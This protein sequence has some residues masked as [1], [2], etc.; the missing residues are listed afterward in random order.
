MGISSAL[1]IGRSAPT[2]AVHSCPAWRVCAGRDHWHARSS[3]DR[4]LDPR[5]S[6]HTATI[7]AGRHRRQRRSSW[8]NSWR[9]AETHHRLTAQSVPDPHRPT[10]ARVCGASSHGCPWH[11]RAVRRQRP[12]REQSCGGRPARGA[13]GHRYHRDRPQR[14]GEPGGRWPVRA[15]RPDPVRRHCTQPGARRSGACWWGIPAE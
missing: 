13:L 4:R 2:C 15:R 3:H 11:C 1:A 6:R 5:R 8:V 7:M 12:G 9:T 10:V 14:A